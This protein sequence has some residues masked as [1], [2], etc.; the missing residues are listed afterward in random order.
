MDMSRKVFISML[1]MV[2]GFASTGMAHSLYQSFPVAGNVLSADKAIKQFS[3]WSPEKRMFFSTKNEIY[4][5]ESQWMIFFCGLISRDVS[6]LSGEQTGLYTAMV[7][8]YFEVY[9]ELLGDEK[10]SQE[11]L[12]IFLAAAEE[13]CMTQ[14]M[15]RMIY[16]LLKEGADPNARVYCNEKLM[17]AYEKALLLNEQALAAIYRN[18]GAQLESNE[19]AIE[20]LYRS[21]MEYR[22]FCAEHPFECGL[23]AGCGFGGLLA[24]YYLDEHAPAWYA[25]MM[26]EAP[27]AN[28]P[29]KSVRALIR[30]SQKL[31][32]NANRFQALKS[33]APYLSASATAFA[34]Y[35]LCA[36]IGQQVDDYL[37]YNNESAQLEEPAVKEEPVKQEAPKRRGRLTREET[38][39]EFISVID[40]MTVED[41]LSLPES[42]QEELIGPAL[43][44]ERLIEENVIHIY[45]NL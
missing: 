45:S 41:F 36:L 12:N 8:Q 29:K 25:E 43:F 39:L 11:L 37:Y 5:Q 9:K 26:A 23:S 38:I 7:I 30:Q 1:M 14:E 34:S 44:R 2:L 17:S 42:L 33:L 35:E 10:P 20:H 40:G 32:Q 24:G 18:Y 27:A 16:Y 31:N 19:T 6:R 22:D 21:L 28:T 15:N 4:S 3:K 13:H